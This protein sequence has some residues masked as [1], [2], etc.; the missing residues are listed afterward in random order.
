MINARHL[1]LATAWLALATTALCQPAARPGTPQFYFDVVT[2]SPPT[3]LSTPGAAYYLQNLHAVGRQDLH[4]ALPGRPVQSAPC[5]AWPTTAGRA[6]GTV[7]E[8]LAELARATTIVIVNEAH[9]ESRHRE[10]IRQLAVALRRQGFTYYAAETLTDAPQRPDE[11]FGRIDAGYYTL[12]PAFGRLLRTVKELGYR[13]VAYEYLGGPADAA[14]DRAALM[15]R[16]EEAQ[17]NNLVTQIFAR[18]PQAKV[19]IHVGYSHAAEVALPNFGGSLEWMAARLK[20]KTGIDPLTIDQ[21][22]CASSSDAVE[23]AAIST[24]LPSG[25]HDVAVAY[26]PTVLFRGRPQWR[27]DAGA[28]AVELP[29]VLVSDEQRTLIEARFD[30]EPP[31]TIPVDRLL[32]WPGERLPLLLPAG[33][34]RIQQYFEGGGAPR[35]LV[36]NVE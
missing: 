32:L 20:A 30:S 28:I 7:A 10:L 13:V 34:I 19:L 1:W 4:A 26:P 27:I 22:R 5:P 23:L 15:V 9:D 6:A 16:R 17:A 33:K 12:E 31:D 24:E 18:E 21:F 11:P 8:Q 25:A 29:D 3:D 35:T 14:A 2:A 36:L